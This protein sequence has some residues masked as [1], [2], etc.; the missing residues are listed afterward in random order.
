M[1]NEDHK[2]SWDSF[3]IFVLKRTAADIGVLVLITTSY[4]KVIL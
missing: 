3:T 2:N 1:D 4:C